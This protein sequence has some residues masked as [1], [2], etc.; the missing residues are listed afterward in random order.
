MP[1]LVS[2]RSDSSLCP[3]KIQIAGRPW[4]IEFVNETTMLGF[5]LTEGDAPSGLTF[6]Q[7]LKIFIGDWTH[8]RMQ[9]ENTLHEVIHAC[10]YGGRFDGEMAKDTDPEEWFISGIDSP[11]LTTLRNNPALVEY[12]MGDN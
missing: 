6:G 3:G 11:L 10:V 5:H 1:Q 4:T 2:V 9:R 8:T 7:S 12:L